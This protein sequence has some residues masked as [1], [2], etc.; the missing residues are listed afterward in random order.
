MA[1]S[2]LYLAAPPM[3]FA[4]A[5]MLPYVADHFYNP[6]DSNPATYYSYDHLPATSDQVQAVACIAPSLIHSIMPTSHLDA[7]AYTY[8]P[9]VDSDASDASLSSLAATPSMSTS[10]SQPTPPQPRSE[11][12]TCQRRNVQVSRAAARASAITIPSDRWKCPNCD[13]VQE[14]RRKPD[15]KR[16]IE[17]HSP[18]GFY[19]CCGVPLVDALALGVP[20]DVAHGSKVSEFEGI[21]MVGGCRR[22]FGRR[23]TYGRHL[24]RKEGICFGEPQALYQPGNR[25]DSRC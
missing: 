10:S 23:D 14:N 7:P 6:G 18:E 1:S 12:I 11:L 22:T 15:L 19:V 4:G 25:S 24:R 20:A 5:N 16:H 9:S 13:H 3:S 8:T 21:F 2:D 17:T